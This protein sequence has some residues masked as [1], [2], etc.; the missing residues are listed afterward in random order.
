[1]KVNIAQG[2]AETQAEFR[3]ICENGKQSSVRE[4][5]AILEISLRQNYLEA[6]SRE[7]IRLACADLSGMLNGLLKSLPLNAERLTKNVK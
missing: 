1:M 4:R 3:K 7:S 2:T 6:N 5:I